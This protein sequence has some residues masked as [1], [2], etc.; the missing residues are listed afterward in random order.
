MV[1]QNTYLVPLFLYSSGASATSAVVDFSAF[2]FGAFFP[3][4][5]FFVG[6]FFLKVFSVVV[7]VPLV[8]FF[9]LAL[10]PSFLGVAFFFGVSFFFGDEFFFGAN[11][12]VLGF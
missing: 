5:T 7:I 10:L 3:V 2:F 8:D 4:E 11:F 1:A 12:F 6:V 9:G